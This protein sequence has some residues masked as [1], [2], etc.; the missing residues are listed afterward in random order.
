M[1]PGWLSGIIFKNRAIEIYLQAQVR[2]E[3]SLTKKQRKAVWEKS[4]GKCWYCGNDLPERGWHADHFWPVIRQLTRV[5]NPPGSQFSHKYV[6]QGEM[7]RSANDHIDNMVPSCAPCNNFKHTYP[8]E[9]FRKELED[10]VNRARK[11]S[12][13]FRNAERFGLIDV[14][15]LKI[16]FWFERQGIPA[17]I[18][19]DSIQII[20]GLRES[21]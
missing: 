13:N 8:V 4:R 1:R 7:Y 2:H 20:K 9:F 11:S 12:V 10:Q 15:P 21:H 18:D 19:R 6:C 16:V 14:K 5:K 17:P 3:M